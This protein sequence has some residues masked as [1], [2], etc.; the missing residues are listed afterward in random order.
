MS[1]NKKEEKGKKFNFQLVVKDGIVT[2]HQ[3]SFELFH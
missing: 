2:D 1:K 3:N